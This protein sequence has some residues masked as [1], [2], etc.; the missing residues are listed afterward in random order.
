[1]LHF[2]CDPLFITVIFDIYKAQYLVQMF[3]STNVYADIWPIEG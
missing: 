2:L 1:M 3:R